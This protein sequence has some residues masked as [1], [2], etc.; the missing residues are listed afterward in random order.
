M[1]FYFSFGNFGSVHWAI[2]R[3]GE[4]IISEEE[5]EKNREKKIQTIQLIVGN[6]QNR[7][8]NVYILR[9]TSYEFSLIC[10][11]KHEGQL[12]E[13]TTQHTHGRMSSFHHIRIISLISIRLR[14]CIRSYERPVL[15]GSHKSSIFLEVRLTQP[16][17]RR[18]SIRN[19]C[20]H[21]LRRGRVWIEEQRSPERT[22]LVCMTEK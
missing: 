15:N 13:R 9:S 12:L 7:M 17:P 20:R 21:R 3:P 1:D 5:M 4:M 2:I 11:S 6:R 14:R 19:R 8:V 10:M 18:L 16:N 22:F